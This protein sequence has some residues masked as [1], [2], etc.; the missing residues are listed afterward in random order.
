MTTLP[1][2]LSLSLHIVL[3][4]YT[5]RLPYLHFKCLVLPP[6]Y[7]SYSFRL[8]FSPTVFLSPLTA[9][10]L[11][12]VVKYRRLQHLYHFLQDVVLHFVYQE[13]LK[14]PQ[15]DKNPSFSVN[16]VTEAKGRQPYGI[17]NTVLILEEI[18]W[19]QMPV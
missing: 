13:P 8:T 3:L 2:S 16:N 9:R 4:S 18:V 12:P 17:R 7:I 19:S 11:K 10:T 6:H 5:A 1:L 15:D 14:D